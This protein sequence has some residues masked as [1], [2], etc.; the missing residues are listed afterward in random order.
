MALPFTPTTPHPQQ[1]LQEINGTL[2]G[3][4]AVTFFAKGAND[5]KKWEEGI[6]KNPHASFCSL[7]GSVRIDLKE[8]S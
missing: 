4:N 5:I 8:C 7:P 3:I 6:L 2:I 1:S